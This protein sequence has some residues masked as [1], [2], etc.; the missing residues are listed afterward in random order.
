MNCINEFYNIGQINCMYPLDVN[1]VNKLW[2]AISSSGKFL[3]KKYIPKYNDIVLLSV[4][5]QEMVHRFLDLSPM[6][7]PN[8]NHKLLSY[9]NGEFYSL[10]EY[11]DGSDFILTEKTIR[12]YLDS[13]IKLHSVLNQIH[14]NELEK[15]KANSFN[16]QEI[17]NE[18]R[19]AKERYISLKIINESFEKLLDF[20]MCF[21]KELPLVSYEIEYKSVIHGD[22]R[23]SNVILNSNTIKFIDFDYISK[24]D[25]LY[26]LSS[27]ITLLS[28]FKKEVCEMFWNIYCDKNN[29]RLSFKQLYLHL[30]TYYIKS[31]F[32]LNIIAYESKEQI[33]RMSLE[34]IKLLEFC[35]SIISA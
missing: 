12:L 16:K 24:G 9:F 1:S 29:L 21:A 4:S 5:A 18:I 31:N 6:I 25:L 2:I 13:I 7:I 14:I 10:Q 3:L 11:I 22:I 15:T 17:I 8:K 34:R 26:E 20:R 30:L 32:P 19:M 33:D 35:N 28:K 27:S 23:P